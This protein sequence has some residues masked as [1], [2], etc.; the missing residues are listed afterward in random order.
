MEVE[1]KKPKEKS[2]VGKKCRTCSLDCS[3]T[4]EVTLKYIVNY[5][6]RKQKAIEVF[7][8]EKPAFTSDTC[9]KK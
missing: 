4:R 7:G 5:E 8:S 3:I 2:K 1:T 9:R 6:E